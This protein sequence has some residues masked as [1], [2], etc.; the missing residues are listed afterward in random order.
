MK[1]RMKNQMKKLLNIPFLRFFFIPFIYRR[2]IR[3]GELGYAYR[4]KEL[5]LDSEYWA[6][7][8]RKFAHIMDKGMQRKDFEVGHG[9]KYF[10]AAKDAIERIED[11]KFKDS[12]VLW[13]EKK[14]EEYSAMQITGDAMVQKAPNG[15][16][17][18]T[19]SLY[20]LIISR[21]SIRWFKDKEVEIEKIQRMA[22][23]LQWC[24]TSCNKQPGKMFVAIGRDK[25]SECMNLCAGG[26]GFSANVPVFIAYCADVRGYDMPHEVVL[27]YVDISLGI[28]NCNLIAFSMG[29]GTT[30]LSWAQSN[31][32]QESEL[33]KLLGIP[34]HYLIIVNSVCGY[35]ECDAPP[36]LRRSPNIDIL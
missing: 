29:L 17:V 25:V 8:L 18:E 33:R 13:A 5:E 23:V 1:K 12:S 35:P 20:E 15:S 22:E 4:K 24:P 28:Q 3:V 16:V 7:R 27:P 10:S 19:E 32:R 21:R 2:V 36:P 14:L 6:K 26:K 31:E 9:I 30:M 11:G 34:K